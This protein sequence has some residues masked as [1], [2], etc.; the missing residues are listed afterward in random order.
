MFARVAQRARHPDKL[1]QKFLHTPRVSRIGN[2]TSRRIEKLPSGTEINIREDGNQAELAQHRQQTLD[3]ARAAEWTSRHATNAN[4][5][6]DVFLQVC[7]EH[8]LQQTREAMIVLRH[9]KDEPVSALY[10]G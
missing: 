7:I 9:N 6:V 2:L 3:H 4:G 5:F 1:V 10:R 8:V